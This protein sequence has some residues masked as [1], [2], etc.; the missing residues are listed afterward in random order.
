MKS[1]LALSDVI[2][3]P[4]KRPA[5]IILLGAEKVLA[6]PTLRLVVCERNEGGLQMLGHSAAEV[7]S[8]MAR[9]GFTWEKRTGADQTV[10]NWIFV[11]D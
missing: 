7:E 9:H 4:T 5:R 11:R 10:D 2:A 3:Q 1:Q 6:N 8:I